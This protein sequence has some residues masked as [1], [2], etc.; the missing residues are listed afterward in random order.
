MRLWGIDIIYAFFLCYYFLHAIASPTFVTGETPFVTG[1]DMSHIKTSLQIKTH[2]DIFKI[3]IYLLLCRPDVWWERSVGCTREASRERRKPAQQIGQLP[4]NNPT[5]EESIQKNRAKRTT[6]E[7]HTHVGQ[8]EKKKKKIARP[9]LE[10]KK[11]CFG[12]FCAP[13]LKDFMVHSYF[14]N[15]SRVS[16]EQDLSCCNSKRPY[17]RNVF[18]ANHAMHDRTPIYIVKTWSHDDGISIF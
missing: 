2:R 18:T 11:I 3:A 4:K 15:C 5:Q 17:T 12:K 14:K 16:L 1:E 7:K 13:P 10:R 8:I 6:L 9:D